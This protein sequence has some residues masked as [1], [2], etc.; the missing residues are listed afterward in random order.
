M[1]GEIVNEREGR[2]EICF[3]QRWGTV[4]SDGWNQTNAE[5][6]CQ[7]LGYTDSGRHGTTLSCS[8]I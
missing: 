6:V 4:G 2:L 1:E 3:G 8:I 7:G 5:I